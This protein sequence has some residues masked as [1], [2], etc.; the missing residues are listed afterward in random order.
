MP[1]LPVRTSN[2][3][4]AS[5]TNNSENPWLHVPTEPPFVLPCDRDRIDD[6]NR[7]CRWKDRRVL[8]KK[9]MPEPYIGNLGTVLTL[10]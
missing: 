8:L 6:Y 9:L 5:M 4:V 3:R 1:I 7:K 2:V 10:R